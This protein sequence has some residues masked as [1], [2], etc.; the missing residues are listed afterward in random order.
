[1]Q[2]GEMALPAHP[3]LGGLGLTAPSLR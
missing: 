2:K 1:M 3:W